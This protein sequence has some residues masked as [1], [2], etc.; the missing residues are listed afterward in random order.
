MAGQHE[1]TGELLV[2]SVRADPAA[3]DELVPLLY[4]ELR[5]MAHR[6]LLRERAGHS[7][8]TTALVHET[9]LRLAQQR[10]VP[11]DR[12]GFLAIA[13]RVM[14][15]V[16][17]DYARRHRA[18]KRDG[19]RQRVSLDAAMN[20]LGSGLGGDAAHVTADERAELLMALDDALGQLATLDPRLVRVVECRFFAGLTED[21]TAEALGITARTVR[22]DWSKAKAWL[23]RELQGWGAS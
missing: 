11:D 18:A 2:P 13:A 3:W 8:N 15:R 20:A 21:E 16:L 7:L 17:T 6:Q 23:Q 5:A 4:A 9:Y 19:A 1:H 10:R 14:R 12:S 22:R